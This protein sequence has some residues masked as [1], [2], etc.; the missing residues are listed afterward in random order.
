MTKACQVSLGDIL[1][2]YSAIQR[3]VRQSCE[4]NGHTIVSLALQFNLIPL[5]LPITKLRGAVYSANR[6]IGEHQTRLSKDQSRTRKMFLLT[7]T[8]RPKKVHCNIIYSRKRFLKIKTC[9]GG[10][11]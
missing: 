1:S 6:T 7:K 4:T 8:K 9:S 5:C 11:G 2:T 10:R 3:Q